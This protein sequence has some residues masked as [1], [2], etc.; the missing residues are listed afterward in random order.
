M[1]TKRNMLRP[2]LDGDTVFVNAAV[3]INMLDYN[4]T[5]RSVNR[6]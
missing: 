3:E 2:S 6:V 5:V 1:A 4:V